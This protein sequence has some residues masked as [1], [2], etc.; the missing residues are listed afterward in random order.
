MFF[1]T[2]T[3]AESVVY[4]PDDNSR[5]DMDNVQKSSNALNKILSSGPLMIECHNFL[6]N[7]VYYFVDPVPHVLLPHLQRADGLFNL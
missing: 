2:A 7:N 4:H 5:T 3:S 1:E 6:C